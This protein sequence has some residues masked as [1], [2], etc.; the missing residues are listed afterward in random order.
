MTL[1]Y[2]VKLENAHCARA[3][4]ELLQKKFKKN[5]YH[6][7][8]VSQIRQIWIQLTTCGKNF[9]RRCAKHAS[10]VWS[11]QWRQW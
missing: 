8:C 3:T 1:H 9:L 6:L 7:N 4:V 11:Y 2:L 10:L 5:L